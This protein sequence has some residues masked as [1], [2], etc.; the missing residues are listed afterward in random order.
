VVSFLVP[1]AAWASAS[2]FRRAGRAW[3]AVVIA[4]T[5][6]L[7]TKGLLDVRE[8]TRAGRKDAYDSQ[9]EKALM[10]GRLGTRGKV[11]AQE[12]D[13]WFLHKAGFRI[14]T[15]PTAL[16]HFAIADPNV[17]NPAWI[18]G[19]ERAIRE[20]RYAVI[21]PMWAHHLPE[22]VVRRL[23]SHLKANYVVAPATNWLVPRP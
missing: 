9:T 18:E 15:S 17:A 21:S 1:V 12:D 14:G 11:F 10:V 23:D 8:K 22:A 4:A 7:G 3:Q 5:C 16:W 6:A 13:F 20:R 19:V 2:R